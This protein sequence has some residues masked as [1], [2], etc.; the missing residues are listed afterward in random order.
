MINANYYYLHNITMSQIRE[1][2]RLREKCDGPLCKH[3]LSKAQEF[4]EEQNVFTSL[5]YSLYILLLM[6]N[7]ETYTHFLKIGVNMIKGIVPRHY[8]K[9]NQCIINNEFPPPKLFSKM[10]KVLDVTYSFCSIF[11]VP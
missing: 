8:K 1:Y 9:L 6:V 5:K 2:G 3:C 7:L 10:F 4:K 11:V